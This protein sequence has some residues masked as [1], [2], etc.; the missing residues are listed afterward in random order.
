MPNPHGLSGEPVVRRIF[1][2]RRTAA[3]HRRAKEKEEKEAHKT[4]RIT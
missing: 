2:R 4:H 3:G 1:H